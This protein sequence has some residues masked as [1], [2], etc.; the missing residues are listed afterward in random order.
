MFEWFENQLLWESLC[1]FIFPQVRFDIAEEQVEKVLK[2]TEFKGRDILDL[3][4]GPGRHSV[5]LAKKGLTVTGVDRSSFL[6]EKAKA[7]AEEQQVTVEWVEE[8]MRKF[9][10][11]GAF[12]LILNM[13]TSFGYFEDKAEDLQV[14]RNIYQSLRPRGVFFID[15]AGKEI[16]AKWFQPTNSQELSDGS[17]LV[18]RHEIIDDWSRIR[19]E[20]IVVK[21]GKAE[22]FRFQH[23][24]YSAQ[25][26]KDRLQQSGFQRVQMWGDLDGNAYGT[27]AQRLVMAAWK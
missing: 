22:V 6:L 8:D 16:V 12:D 17:L 3:C 24:I 5:A 9:V 1:P 26:L 18:Q 15:V 4:C 7:R 10:R 25:E 14:L 13:F 20:W 21:Q 27:N 2:L 23:T 19:N 11:P